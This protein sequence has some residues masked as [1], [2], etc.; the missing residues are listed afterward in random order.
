MND[1]AIERIAENL[2]PLAN[3]AIAFGGKFLVGRYLIGPALI[4]LILLLSLVFHSVPLGGIGLVLLAV[5][6]VI[7]IILGFLKSFHNA[8]STPRP[9]NRYEAV[10]YVQEIVRRRYPFNFKVVSDWVNTTH[11]Y[12]TTDAWVAL[13]NQYQEARGAFWSQMESVIQ[14]AK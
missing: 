3:D 14:A 7:A 1:S 4:G 13:Y 8:F 11:P 10:N 6:C 5:G 2:P 12:E 9:T